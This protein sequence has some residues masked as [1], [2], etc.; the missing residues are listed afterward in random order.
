MKELINQI[1]EQQLK[2]FCLL[3]QFYKNKEHYTVLP[4]KHRGLYWLWTNVSF[5]T[6]KKAAPRKNTQEVPIDKLVRYRE[7]L[8]NTARVQK[9]DFKIVYN[10]IGGY[11]KTP[12][13]FGLRER[14]NQEIH[15]NDYRTG[16]LNILN[17]DFKP[18]NWAVSFFDFDNPMNYEILKV[19]DS[20][21]TYIEYA[22]D[23]EMIWRLEYGT[24]I[25]CRY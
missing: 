6:L 7:K 10:G 8:N 2:T 18:D 20:T 12:A 17:R 16:T 9:G 5:E 14:I 19:L 24:P 13:S 25:L 1:H 23:L 22:K 4:R 15:C 11:K 21:N 3:N